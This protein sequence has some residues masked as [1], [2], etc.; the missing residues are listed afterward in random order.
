MKER[1]KKTLEQVKKG[2]DKWSKL[3][4]EEQKVVKQKVAKDIEKIGNLVKVDFSGSN[5]APNAP[6]TAKRKGG[7][8]EEDFGQRMLRIRNSLQKI[9]SLMSELRNTK[10][11]Q[12]Q[13][14]KLKSV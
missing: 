3:D 5:K 11:N 1:N 4:A 10:A 13:K 9:N 7:E 6:K 2:G 8:S 12:E 14:P